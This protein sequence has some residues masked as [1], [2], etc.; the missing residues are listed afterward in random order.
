MTTSRLRFG[1]EGKVFD[2]YD[3]RAGYQ[4]GESDAEY[5]LSGTLNFNHLSKLSGQVACGTDSL[6]GCSVAN[7]TGISTLTPAQL[8][9]LYYTNVRITQT[10]QALMYASVTGPII[11]LPAGP[12]SFALGGEHRQESGFD[13]PDS[14]IAQGDGSA[15]AQPTAGHYSISSAYLE[16]NIPVF[17]DEW[18]AKS[19]TINASGRYDSTS[20]FGDAET[21]K[22]GLDYAVTD[23]IRFRASDSTGFRAPQIKELFGGAYQSFPQGNDPCK[24]NG[25]VFKQ[26]ANCIR[27]LNAVGVNPATFHRQQRAAPHH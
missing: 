3:W 8:K 6:I 27:D 7:F 1:L 10:S 9:Y 4:F 14:I 17:K 15:D 2:N 25:G 26:T 13:H 24:N 20:T 11:D 16:I 5:Q 21:Y 23:D 12:L 18:F 22:I 19:L